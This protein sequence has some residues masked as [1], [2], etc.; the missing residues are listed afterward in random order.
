MFV[1]YYLTQ[2]GHEVTLVD[3][4]PTEFVTS[5]NN[6]GFITPSFSPA[7][8]I[9]IAKV[10]STMFGASGPL[11]ISPLTVLRN[12]RWFVRA[13]R[14]GVTAHEKEVIELGAKSLQLFEEFF[15]AEGLQPDRQV[16]LLGLYR[17]EGV[18]RR[19]AERFGGSF[20]A[21]PE[22]ARLGFVGLEGGVLAR[23]EISIDPGEFCR[24]LRT[25]LGAMGVT[26]RLGEKASLSKEGSEARVTLAGGDRLRADSVV[27]ASGAMSREVL[28]P[29]G[30]DPGVLPARGLVLLFDS[31]GRSVVPCPTLLE[32]YGI[33]LVQHKSGTI[34]LTSFF[35]MTGYKSEFAPARR[36][37]LESTASAH[38]PGLSGLKLLRQGTGFRPCTPDQ[39][40]VI[41]RVPG[42][43]NLLVATGNCRLGITLAPVTGYMIRSM[44]GGR[45]PAGVPWRLFDPGRFA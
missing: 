24:S 7:P 37:W 12:A 42:Y 28:S 41:G 17:S 45:E 4:E 8:H 14:E 5:S 26:L 9:G 32:D 1:S 3:Q 44:V 31:A 43:G 36:E 25:R 33:A 40:P 15:Q 23:E 10:A 29:L 11:Y 35:E 2:D 13:A 22:I 34:R 20:V 38:L 19:L 30:Y 27:V 39:I 21:A 18:A 6:G 16:G